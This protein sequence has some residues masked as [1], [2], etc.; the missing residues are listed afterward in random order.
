MKCL[1]VLFFVC[2]FSVFWEFPYEIIFLH[3]WL[4]SDEQFRFWVY[5]IGF[6]LFPRNLY[7]T[8]CGFCF[9]FA[10][11]LEVFE[12]WY[13]RLG[14][15]VLE[16]NSVETVGLY[17][18]EFVIKGFFGFVLQVYLCVPHFSSGNIWEFISEICRKSVHRLDVLSCTNSRY[19]AVVISQIL[20]NDFD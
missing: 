16:L 10:F 19:C 1:W 13:M 20:V 9:I 7:C 12:N 14:P 8:I 4:N 6:G 15:F 17:F 18:V 5:F 11:L 2:F 3:Y